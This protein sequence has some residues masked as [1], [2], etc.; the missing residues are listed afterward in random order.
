MNIINITLNQLKMAIKSRQIILL[1]VLP[2]IMIAAM[3]NALKS[4]FEANN[5]I[6][7]FDVLYVN[8]DTGTIGKSFDSMILNVASKYIHVINSDEKNAAEEVTKGKYDEAII[9]P[10]E[11]SLKV[12]NGEKCAIKVVSSGKDEVKDYVV[13][14]L[15]SSF[16]ETVNT[17]MGL[18]KGYSE[19]LPGANTEEE[20]QILARLQK[21]LGS[22]YIAVKPEYQS[23]I[24]KLSSFQYFA[25]GMLLFFMLT[26]GIGVGNSIIKERSNKIYM[27]VNSFPVKKS[28]YLLGHV[29]SNVI[30]AIL[31]AAAIIVS[32]SILFGVDWGTNYMGIAITVLLM[33]FTASSLGVLASSIVNSEKVLSSG[34][35]IILWFIVFLGGGFSD[36]PSLEPIGRFTFYKWGFN[37]LANF[38]CGES[39]N[40]SASELIM[41]A[42]LMFVSWSV[43]LALF[44]RRARNE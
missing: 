1:L 8:E 44:G 24:K 22:D 7:K 40:S 6:Q 5:S 14:S 26:T 30:T 2:I 25:A 29:L 41:L 28:E 31:Q 36:F 12:S 18:I 10:K 20:A 43:A 23:S 11:L 19:N 32:S 42:V 17:N 39:I 35:T 4:T 9:I 13:N 3:G 16:S 33:I 37:T 34:L 38:I 21:G 27:R 15:V